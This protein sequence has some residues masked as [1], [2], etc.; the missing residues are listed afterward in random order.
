M[1]FQVK[2]HLFLLLLCLL[3]NSVFSLRGSSTKSQSNVS[4]KVQTELSQSYYA[5][6]WKTLF[7]VPRIH[8]CSKT[9]LIRRIR[10]ELLSEM[11][12]SN[13]GKKRPFWWVK[14]WGYGQ[15]AYLF[16]FIDPVLQI[17]AAAEFKL[18][19]KAIQSFPQVDSAYPDPYDF[20]ALISKDNI[21][22]T[23]KMIKRLKLFTQNFD[24]TIYNVSLNA[25]QIRKAISTF[26]WTSDLS[27][28]NYP[29]KF[30]S[31]YDMNYDGRLNF[32]ELIL[33]SI[34]HNQQL[35]G[36]PEPLCSFCYFEI[37]KTIDAIFLYLDCDN[38]GYLSAEEI[39]S[40]LPKL[41]RPTQQWNLFSFGIDD[42]IRTASINDFILKNSHSKDGYISRRE[43]R[44]GLL[45]GF[46][47]RQTE[48]TKIVENDSRNLKKLRWK[49]NHMIDVAL[50]NFYKKKMR[51]EFFKK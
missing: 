20:K 36:L 33:G 45:L 23:K 25:V 44:V 12:S 29:A 4:N 18:V 47:D 43:F 31:K 13:K 17:K 5:N 14:Q 38:D 37:G 6:M 32:R 51:Q 35:V 22:L 15:T 9:R 10:H 26:K 46:W 3:L 50:Y 7:T 11:N 24:E 41:S 42:N 49:E 8:A 19:Y 27:N 28:P 2:I 16:D 30:V 34:Y 40:N 39:W 48:P 21:N 1:K